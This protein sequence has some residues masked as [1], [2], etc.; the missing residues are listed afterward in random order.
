VARL[1]LID[2]PLAPRTPGSAAGQAV[3]TDD[4]DTPLPESILGDFEQ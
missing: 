4:F 3:V 2:K 1:V